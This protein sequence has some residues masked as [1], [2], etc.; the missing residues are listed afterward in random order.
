MIKIGGRFQANS[1]LGTCLVMPGNKILGPKV[2][3]PKSK[4]FKNVD[5]NS[6]NE[7]FSAISDNFT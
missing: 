1:Q 7:E 5:F 2:V 6:E 3:V 4:N